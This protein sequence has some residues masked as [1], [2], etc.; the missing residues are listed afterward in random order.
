M[1]V[2]G[3]TCVDTKLRGIKASFAV[4]GDRGRSHKSSCSHCEQLNCQGQP[5]NEAIVIICVCVPNTI[6]DGAKPKRVP[7]RPSIC[8]YTMKKYNTYVRTWGLK[9]SGG[10]YLKGTYFWKLTVVFHFVEISSMHQS[11]V[12]GKFC[13]QKYLQMY[14][15]NVLAK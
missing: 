11:T 5:A 2:F 6:D 1:N 14:H 9:R 13:G 7:R 15:C 3:G 12:R 8:I 4:G 10:I